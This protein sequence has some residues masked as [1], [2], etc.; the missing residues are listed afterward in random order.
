M[1]QEIITG[2]DNQLY[3]FT[4]YCNKEQKILAY[5]CK[6]KERQYPIHFGIGCFHVSE[7]N[8]EVINIGRRFVEN[9]KY[10]GIFGIELKKESRD[11]KYKFGELNMRFLMGNELNVKSGIDLPYI[12]Y[13]DMSGQKV[14]PVAFFKDNVK[15]TNVFL[16]ISS[17]WQYHRLKEIKLWEWIKSYKGKV[18]DTYFAMDDLRPFG[19]ILY[20][21]ILTI[22][23]KFRK[24]F[25]HRNNGS[26]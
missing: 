3:T 8:E 13:K 14:D 22:P 21:Y 5:I 18:S 10:S 24:I 17:F 1:L 2:K 23:R 4:G 11:G 7:N 12:Y 6:R 20:K 9:I 25:S 26:E 19:Y 15:L 16:D